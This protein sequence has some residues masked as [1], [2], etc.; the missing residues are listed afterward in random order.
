MFFHSFHRIESVEV[1]ANPNGITFTLKCEKVTQPVDLNFF[2]ATHGAY[3][4]PGT[5]E[6]ID[7]QRK[8]LRQMRDKIDFA[9]AE[10]G[11]DALVKT[12]VQD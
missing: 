10:L 8:M 5:P 4:K 3:H 1:R 2:P 7:S 6:T 11:S 9:L 12:D